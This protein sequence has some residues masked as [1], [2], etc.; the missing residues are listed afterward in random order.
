MQPI[1][2][3]YV[4]IVP[5]L[6]RKEEV[7]K[8]PSITSGFLVGL[9]IPRK[10][11]RY[12]ACSGEISELTVTRHLPPSCRRACAPAAAPALSSWFACCRWCH[13]SSAVLD[14]CEHKLTVQSDLPRS[15]DWVRAER[16]QTHKNQNQEE[17]FLSPNSPS[18][19][20]VVLN[21]GN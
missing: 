19:I 21:I 14:N 11:T 17:N 1:L 10:Q 3:C 7:R 9:G 5:H 20:L 6:A 16:K 8:T 18:P 12:F 13:P 2:K 15:Q 4:R